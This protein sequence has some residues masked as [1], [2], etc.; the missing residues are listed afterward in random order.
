[1]TE[2]AEQIIQLPFDKSIIHAIKRVNK[3]GLSNLAV[4]IR[5]SIIPKG[6]DEIIVA[7][8][9][10]VKRLELKNDY[11][12]LASLKEQK[13]K[14]AKKKEAAD[15]NLQEACRELSALVRE[16]MKGH[17][18]YKVRIR[19]GKIVIGLEKREGYSIFAGNLEDYFNGFPVAFL[20]HLKDL[21]GM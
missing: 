6:H 1:M 3:R 5:E 7:W 16:E 18:C 11:D 9:E 21:D 8:I 12:V 2:T 19:E 10:M 4:F 14:A 17:G 20:G 15:Q 13:E